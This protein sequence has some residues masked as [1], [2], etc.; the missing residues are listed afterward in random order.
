MKKYSY[1]I[2]ALFALFA[3][4]AYAQNIIPRNTHQ[5]LIMVPC[6]TSAYVQNLIEVENGEKLLFD[7]EGL[8]F[9]I[10]SGERTPE[11]AKAPA[12]L[13]V[14]MESGRWSLV[15]KPTNRL[16]CLLVNGSEFVAGGN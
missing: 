16:W 9:A 5:H 1:T 13:Y 12:S 11:P 3:T 14:N 4:S 7:A 8:V 6:D 10:P 15:L 2:F